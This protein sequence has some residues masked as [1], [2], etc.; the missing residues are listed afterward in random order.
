MSIYT[1]N[2]SEPWFSLIKVGL[3]KV[4]G[5]LNKSD[6]NK[7]N[8]GDIIIFENNNFNI[9]RTL[10]VKITKIKYYSSFTDYLTTEKLNRCLPGIDT[11]EDGLAVYYAFYSKKNEDKFGIISIKIKV[12]L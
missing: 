4:E 1:K 5:R 7:M 6:F 2:L 12:I 3:K 10:K 9:K 11:I 8:I